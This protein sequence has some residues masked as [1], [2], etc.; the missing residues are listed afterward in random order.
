M[1]IPS[2]FCSRIPAWEPHQETNRH[3]F[4]IFTRF[5]ALGSRTTEPAS[6]YITRRVNREHIA[7]DKTLSYYCETTRQILRILP[8]LPRLTILKPEGN[9]VQCPIQ[10]D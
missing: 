9:S 4:I 1:T 5:P 3:R 10:S 8:S 6:R 2:D 7:R